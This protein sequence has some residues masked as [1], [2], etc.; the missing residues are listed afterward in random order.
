MDGCFWP[1]SCHGALHLWT[2]SLDEDLVTTVLYQ[3]Y[4]SLEFTLSSGRSLGFSVATFSAVIVLISGCRRTPLTPSEIPA[5]ARR[6]SDVRG[7]AE[8]SDCV[9]INV[10]VLIQ[11]FCKL[12]KCVY[13]LWL[14]VYTVCL[15]MQN[16]QLFFFSSNIS[17]SFCD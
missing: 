11:S 13:M 4:L 7:P 8:T 1:N 16:V 3:L 5:V 15:Y 9:H 6:E 2:K 10:C 12:N 14:F 17:L